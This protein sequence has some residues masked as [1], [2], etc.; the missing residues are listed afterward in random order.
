MVEHISNTVIARR[1]LRSEAEQ[2]PMKQSVDRGRSIEID[3]NLNGLLRHS[4]GVPRNDEERVREILSTVMDPEIPTLSVIDL[5][6]ITGVSMSDDGVMVRLLPTFVACPATNYIRANITDALSK[7][8]FV[9]PSVEMETE[10]SWSS[11]R[12]TE[13]GRKL[14]EEF[15]LGAPVQIDGVLSLN[16]IEHVDCPHC[17]SKN[18]ELRSMFGSTLCRSIHYCLDC[19]QGFE[20]FKPL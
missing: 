9:N 17:G 7:S 8:G 14:L 3:P 1:K 19:K 6:M 15:G 11:D 13:H 4:S 16:M 10:L 20:R 18:T 12:V 5:G 2:F